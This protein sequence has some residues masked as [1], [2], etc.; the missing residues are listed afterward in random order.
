MT[1]GCIAVCSQRRLLASQ[2]FPLP[3][4]RTL[5]LPR[6]RP[7]ASHP[8]MPS[9]SL[10]GLPLWTK[11]VNAYPKSIALSRDALEGKGPQRWPQKRLEEVAKAVGGG[12]CRL[13]TP[14]KLALAVRDPLAGPRLGA[15]GGYFPPFQ[16]IPALSY[17]VV[18]IWGL[19]PW[20]SGARDW[21]PSKALMSTSCP[22]P[23]VSGSQLM[24]DSKSQ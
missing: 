1:P 14:L 15:G 6:R 16:C 13:Q 19:V 17:V 20:E 11:F 18:I 12:C 24:W 22:T 23:P 2:H 10:P 3:F 7:S 21:G 5:S 9:L 8:L 4:P